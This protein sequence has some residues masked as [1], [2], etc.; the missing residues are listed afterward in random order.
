M[1]YER[2]ETPLLNR[3]QTALEIKRLI[4]DFYTDLDIIKIPFAGKL[5]ALSSLPFNTYFDYIRR[6]PYKR[7]RAPV[8]QIGRPAWV[9]EKRANGRDCKKAAIMISA[10][11]KYHRI[12]FRLIGS[13]TRK[14][15]AIHHI[16]PQMF[17]GGQWVNVDATYSDYEIGQQKTVTAKEIL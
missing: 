7:D 4:N 14:D 6:L 12:P 1:D 13:S 11:L 16:F 17:T 15:R 2:T 8:E 5:V 9:M 10:Y 3:K